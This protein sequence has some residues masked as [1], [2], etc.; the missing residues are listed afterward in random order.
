MTAR[1]SFSRHLA[2]AMTAAVLV[3]SAP[4]AS[5]QAP[6][7]KSWMRTGIDEAVQALD[8]VASMKKLSPQKKKDLVEFA[9]GNTLFVMSHEMGH[10]VIHEMDL[11]VLGREEDAADSYAILLALQL[12]PAYSERI[13]TDA[14]KAWFLSAYRSKR[15]GRALRFYG[16]HGLDRQ[17]AFNVICMMV[18]SD[19]DRFKPLAKEVRLPQW[20]QGSC[21]RDYRAASW[22]WEEALKPHRRSAG[23]PKTTISVAYKDEEK[24][25][26]AAG[27]MSQT[28]VLETFADDAAE[29]FVWR[30]PFSMEARACGEANARWFFG[31]QT[32][33][34]CYELV[35][36]FVELFQNYAGRLPYRLRA[37]Q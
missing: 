15:A 5:A 13:L 33:V 9:V 3:A 8:R 17:R 37:G 21:V 4:P 12:A 6:E 19:P 31:T 29:R 28:G 26:V 2:G 7:Q 18:G 24:F 14:A 10:V 25:P 36:H 34:L 22:S 20:R 23:Q 30:R 32:L 11:P 16:E 27:I 1:I 35:E